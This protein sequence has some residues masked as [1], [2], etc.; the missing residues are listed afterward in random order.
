MNIYRDITSLP[1]LQNLTVTIGMF[2]GIHLGHR[3]ILDT[4]MT[5]AA[6]LG[7]E[8]MVITFD[9]HPRIALQKEAGQ[10]RFI[11]TLEEKIE[12]L[13]KLDIHHLL[14]IPFTKDFA[15]YSAQDF[16]QKILIKKL[17]AHCVIVGYDHHFGK[18]NTDN[19][20]IDVLLGHHN[21][22]VIKVQQLIK[23]GRPVSSTKIRLGLQ[24]GRVDKAAECL[25]Y[26]Y[27]LK[28]RVEEG[29]QQGRKIGFPTANLRLADIKKVIPR[30]GV[31]AVHVLVDGNTY[32]GMMNIGYKPTLTDGIYSL[33]V[34][35]IDFEGDLYQKELTVSF[36][37]FIR[38]E[39]KFASKEELIAQIEK[40]RDMV[41]S[42]L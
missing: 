6:R 27:S 20:P 34:H 36:V 21:L 12:R 30:N 22:G 32:L 17:D 10:L 28:A 29:L 33:E 9:P 37:R 35:L 18:P 16:I 5:E 39:K 23:E 14:V 7:G 41:V 40:D 26:N 42:I 11:T 4:M 13:S 8:N 25:G 38:E 19:P 15:N 1:D 24:E 3:A 31:Y 2:D